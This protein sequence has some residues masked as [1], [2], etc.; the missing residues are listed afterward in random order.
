LGGGRQW[1]SWIHVQDVLRGIAHLCLMSEAGKP[2]HAAYNFCAPQSLQ[3]AEFHRTAA[4]L[5]RRPCLLPT[6]GWPMRLLLGEQA[7]LLLEGQRIAPARF[8]RSGFS[9]QYAQ[10]I[11]ALRDLC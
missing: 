3:Q 5:L 9:F 10:L 4:R 11:P 2:L 6:P 1:L 8:A 7:D